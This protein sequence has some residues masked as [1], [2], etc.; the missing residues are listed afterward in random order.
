MLAHSKAEPPQ[1]SDMSLRRMARFH[2]SQ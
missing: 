1:I 2:E